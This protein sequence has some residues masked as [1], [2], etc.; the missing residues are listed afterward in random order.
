MRAVTIADGALSI[1]ERPDPEPG[2]GEILVAVR[3]AGVN[4]ADTFPG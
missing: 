4:G 2:S 1:A 3:A